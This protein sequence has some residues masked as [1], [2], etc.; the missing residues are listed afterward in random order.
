MWKHSMPN[1]NERGAMYKGL[2]HPRKIAAHVAG[3]LIGCAPASVKTA[4]V[5]CFSS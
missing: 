4:N 3:G 2:S 5:E 1:R